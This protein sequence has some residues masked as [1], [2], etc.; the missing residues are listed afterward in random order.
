MIAIDNAVM[1]LIL[2]IITLW[3]WKI[4]RK[5]VQCP[6]FSAGKEECEQEGGM[7]FAGSKPQPG[8]SCQVLLK[9]I[10]KAAKEEFKS[11]SSY[12]RRMVVEYLEGKVWSKE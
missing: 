5:D 4:E 10:D 6:N 12:L 2:F 3:V 7:S 8:D 9:K 11:R 1:Y